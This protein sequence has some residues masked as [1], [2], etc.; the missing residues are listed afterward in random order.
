MLFRVGTKLTEILEKLRGD[1][2]ETS[3]CKVGI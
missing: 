2:D 1:L 3:S